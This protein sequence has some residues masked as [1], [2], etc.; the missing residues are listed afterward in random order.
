[1]GLRQFLEEL[2]GLR[3]A[4]SGLLDSSQKIKQQNDQ[5]TFFENLANQGEQGQL[6]AQATAAGYQQPLQQMSEQMFAG[7]RAGLNA[8]QIAAAGVEQPVADVFA[9]APADQQH[10]LLSQYLQGKRSDMSNDLAARR[11][12]AA[13]AKK[14]VTADERAEKTQTAAAKDVNKDAL[15]LD[16]QFID[17]RTSLAKAQAALKAGKV[18]TDNVVMNYIVR[19]LAGEKGP[20][21]EGDLAR[22]AARYIG[23]DLDEWTQFFQGGDGSRLSPAQRKTYQDILDS[24]DGHIRNEAKTSY[25]NLMSSA[26]ATYPKL[27]ENG[28]L[29]KLFKHRFEREGLE[30]LKGA[31][32]SLRVQEV[33]GKK[34]EIQVPEGAAV[35]IDAIK[36]PSVKA[37]VLKVMQEARAKGKRISEKGMQAL[38][39][40]AMKMD[41][42]GN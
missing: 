11:L 31:D 33:G 35:W 13:L 1:M 27:A 42:G 41:G 10:G 8:E 34:Q 22:A 20:L 2:A 29:D 14:D 15:K 30:F 28:Q 9:T 6:V 3:E 19:N 12:E 25:T 7:K 23:T 36:S 5:R 4:S 26:E 38:K 21:N 32:G 17:A 24:M 40:N 39:A 18:T 16:K 37:E